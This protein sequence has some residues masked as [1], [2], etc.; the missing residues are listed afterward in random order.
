MAGGGQ[1]HGRYAWPYEVLHAAP[2]GPYPHIPLYL[3]LASVQ[4]KCEARNGLK[5]NRILES[6]EGLKWWVRGRINDEV[7]WKCWWKR[8][9]SKF[10]EHRD[11]G[12]GL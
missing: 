1:A 7:G 8:K 5:S 6:G 2:G 4:T 10:I 11:I 9:F 12:L 3:P